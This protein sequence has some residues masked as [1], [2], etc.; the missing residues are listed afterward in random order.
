[1][2]GGTLGWALLLL[3]RKG[4]SQGRVSGPGLGLGHLLRVSQDDCLLPAALCHAA[5]AAA[6]AQA[7]C[8]GPGW[9]PMVRGRGHFQLGPAPAHGEWNP[10]MLSLMMTVR[11]VETET[12][13]LGDKLRIRVTKGARVTAEEG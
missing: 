7:T 11:G 1:M 6:K 9:L 2:L 8:G 10:A 12:L 5:A 4:V 3:P 13:L